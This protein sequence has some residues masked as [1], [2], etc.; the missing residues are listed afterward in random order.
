[1]ENLINRATQITP[2]DVEL[3][4]TNGECVLLRTDAPHHMLTLVERNDLVAKAVE[5]HTNFRLHMSKEIALD[6]YVQISKD[7]TVVIAD[8]TNRFSLIYP[9]GSFLKYSPLF[10]LGW[11]PDN[12]LLEVIVAEDKLARFVYK[13]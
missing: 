12:M 4:M 2:T 5:L 9:N 6:S 3:V 10:Y 7:D 1:M 13:K 11:L 8:D